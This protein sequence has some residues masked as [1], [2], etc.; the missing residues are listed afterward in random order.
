MIL[1]LEKEVYFGKPFGEKHK[2]N[3]LYAGIR[4][5]YLPIR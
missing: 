5:R 1:L 3:I 4:T 2:K